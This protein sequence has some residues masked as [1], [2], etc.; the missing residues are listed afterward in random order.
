MGN[1]I[2]FAGN[3]L[4]Q[5]FWIATPPL[6][7]KNLPS[8]AGKVFIVTGGYAG[9]GLELCKILYAA[10]GIVYVAGR[11]E[12][13]AA[14]A[15][16]AMKSAHPNSTGKLE[17]LHVDLSDLRTIKPA[18]EAF[19]AR[20]SRLDV[21]TNN[22]GVMMPPRGSTTQQAHELQ[23]G[24]NC[25]GPYLLTKL[26]TPLMDTTASSA[27]AGSVRVTWAGSLAVDA[28]S[29]S[30]G[31]I[32]FTSASDSTPVTHGNPR[33]DY[34]QSKAGNVYLASESARR[35]TGSSGVVHVAWNPGNLRSELQRHLD[36]AS[37]AV[38]MALS[39]PPVF[40]AYTE[41]YAGWS[42]DISPALSGSYVLPWGR[43]GVYRRDIASALRGKADGGTGGAERFWDWCEKET[44][45]FA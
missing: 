44:K 2:S 33:T 43:V 24:T 13:K 3:V 39:Y 29:P 10:H 12:S 34:G 14:S 37:R 36:F 18:A 27:A 25:L 28:L 41:L 40:G 26:L 42:A 30:P 9:V 38:S 35:Y 15:I 5:M 45:A 7:E 17:Y 31:G 8:Q 4:S 6:T 16:A 23:M 11:S 32:A 20:E 21:L 22:A 1:S 19:L